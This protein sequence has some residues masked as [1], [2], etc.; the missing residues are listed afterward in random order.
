MIQTFQI[1]VTFYLGEGEEDMMKSGVNGF[2]RKHGDKCAKPMKVEGS[3]DVPRELSQ[4]H[5]KR[6]V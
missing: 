4:V 1:T 2:G 3:E 5:V 6:D